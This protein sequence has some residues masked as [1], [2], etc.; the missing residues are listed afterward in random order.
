MYHHSQLSLK[1]KTQAFTCRVPFQQPRVPR[2]GTKLLPV[3]AQSSIVLGY[4]GTCFVT[5]PINSSDHS[6]V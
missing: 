3:S 6:M 4:C 1:K 2:D 5:I